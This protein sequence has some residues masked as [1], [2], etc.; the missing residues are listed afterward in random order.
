MASLRFDHVVIAVRDLRAAIER[1]RSL[2]FAVEE[3]GRHTGR[4]TE[5]AVI[6]FGLDYIELLAVYDQQEAKNSALGGQDLL[7]ALG[8]RD[9]VLLGYALATDAIEQIAEN[10]R[11]SNL[12]AREPFAMERTRPDGE[13]LSWRLFIP[14]GTAWRRPWPFFIQ[15]DQ[16]DEQRLEVEKAGRH[17]NGANA[18]IEVAIGVREWIDVLDLY[19]N[20]IGLTKQDTDIVTPL[21]MRVTHI[22]VGEKSLEI[23][24]P[25]ERGPLQQTIDSYGEGVFA[26]T[27]RVRNLERTR[28]FLKKQRVAFDDSEEAETGAVTI[29]ASASSGVRIVFEQREQEEQL[30]AEV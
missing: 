22:P 10:F 17:G 24:T 30:E 8:E 21:G 20:R 3:G 5:N 16:S 25:D 26:I 23:V 29:P 4:G 1:Y 28:A 27:L 12:F 9:E 14:A 7:A 11:G 13:R 19:Q 6:R 18:W 2:G 15:W